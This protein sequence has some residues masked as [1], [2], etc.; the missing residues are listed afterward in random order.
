MAEC[1][2]RPK[3]R[4]RLTNALKCL[5][6][7]APEEPALSVAEGCVA[8]RHAVS[9]RGTFA[10]LS[11]DSAEA[12]CG[13]PRFA[14]NDPSG[15]IASVTSF[16]RNDMLFNAFAIDSIGVGGILRNGS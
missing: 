9:L 16:P 10:L 13:I 3:N 1:Q 2:L 8:I 15:Q 12:V 4:D 14:R 6:L 5:S 11:V 7:R